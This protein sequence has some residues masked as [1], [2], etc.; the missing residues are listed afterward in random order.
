MGRSRNEKLTHD[1]AREICIRKGSKA[2][3]SG[4]IA[5]LGSHFSIG[6]KAIGCRTGDIIASTQSEA[7]SRENVLQAL[8]IAAADLR[9]ALGESFSSVQK[10][11]K[12]LDEVTTTSLKALREYAQATS[13]A[14][15]AEAIPYYKRAIEADPNFASAYA[16]LATAFVNLGQEQTGVENIRTAYELRNRVSEREKIKISAY[17]LYETGQLEKA[18]EQYQLLSREYPRDA[19]S[20]TN[21]AVIYSVLGQNDKAA[22]E[23]Q[24]ALHSA[25]NDGDSAVAMGNLVGYYLALGRLDEARAT[26]EEALSKKLDSAGLRLNLYGLCFVQNDAT[27]MQQQVEWAKGKL[28]IEDI[29]F[30][31]QSETEAFHGRLRDARE[32]TARAIESAKHSDANE[33]A[34]LWQV[35]G[36]LHESEFGNTEQ[37]RREVA[38]AL[39]LSSGRDVRAQATLALALV[40]ESSQSERLASK[41]N[42]DFPS[43]TIVQNYWIPTIRAQI[44]V[45]RNRPDSAISVLKVAVPYELGPTNAM[46]PVYIRGNAELRARNG[47]A[48]AAEFQNIVNHRTAVQNIPIGSLAHLGLARSYGQQ[49]DTVMARTAYQDFFALWKD[50]DADIPILKQ[51]KAEYARLQ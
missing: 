47:A 22:D 1:V 34:A 48:A 36:A 29:F 7:D 18:L 28:G 42:S 35:S 17:Y 27:C 15:D 45:S 25:T 40:G 50:A 31:Q 10:F 21:S 39:A 16:A 51:A 13:I 9:K 30:A 46:Y 12:P 37:A 3:L 11:D 4:S 5:S 41:L 19:A 49:G 14:D 6:L 26:V 32:L 33:T 2:L 44:E 38:S 43:H 24:V 23:T 8:S 20:H